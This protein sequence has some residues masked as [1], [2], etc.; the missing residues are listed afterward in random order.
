MRLA[1][2]GF[3]HETVT[4]LPEETG[5]DAFELGASRGAALLDTLRGS[6]SVAGGFITAAEA[7]GATL[8]GLVWAEASPSGPVA[9]AA[10]EHYLTEV[11]D[12]LKAL[13]GEI[14][15]L[16]LHLHGAMATPA[17]PDAET[18]FLR[19]L[20][21]A[22]GERLPIALAMDLHGNLSPEMLDL[23]DVVAGYH[24]SPH[25]D[26]AETGRRAA[27]LLIGG[28]QGE[29]RPTMAIA[30][31]PLVLPSIFTATA[32]APLSAIMAEARAV[33][34]KEGVLDI[35]VFTGFAYADVPD[36]GFSVVVVTDDRPEMAATV[37]DEL[38]AMV[39]DAREALFKR[40]LILPH[41]V[42]VDRA[43]ALARDAAKPVVILEHADRMN[44]S[45][46]VLAELAA[47][48]APSVAV[49][50]LWDPEAVAAAIAAGVGQRL[51]LDVGGK[52]S[53]RAGGPV[54][55]DA[56][57][58]FA[59]PKAFTGTGPMRRGVPVDLGPT[60]VLEAGGI[61][62]IVTTSQLSA[63]DAD[64]FHQFGLH[65]EDFDIIVLRS[66]THFRAVYEPIAET[67][68]IAETPDWGPADLATLPYRRARPGVFPITG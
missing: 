62:L 2:A 57:V 35:S 56:V 25:I 52:S 53:A 18:A 65:P 4:F 26:M 13:D 55:L 60:A 31:P 7:A 29:I 47:A 34:A 20:R 19:G 58:R 42:A 39:T 64:P 14:D 50:Y 1:I 68:L 43:L 41:T 21:A 45:T 12:G 66:K 8:T 46:Y 10:F 48:R 11:S 36:I 59:G 16:L 32:L 27:R 22:V 28:L 61:T 51:T 67:I 9:D 23:V 38:A 30:K 33:E 17:R 40:E 37:A 5:R 63:I 49:P 3:A 24:Q 6:S 54:T 15:G 44:D